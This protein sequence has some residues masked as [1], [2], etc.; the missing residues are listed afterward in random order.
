[1][2]DYDKRAFVMQQIALVP[3]AK[4]S[5]D[6]TMICCC[7]HGEKTPSLCV[8]HRPTDDNPGN[9]YC[10]G[11]GE[12]GTW[13]KLADALGLERFD[14]KPRDRYTYPLPQEIEDNQAEEE[15]ILSELPSHKVWRQLPT[16]FLKEIGCKL[17]QV[18]YLHALSQR[19]IY[20]PVN[21]Q[22]KTEGYIKA[23]MRKEPG[24][25]SYINK[26]GSW[27]KSKGLFPYDYSIARMSDKKAVVLVEG[28]RDALRLLHMGIPALC[29]MGTQNWNDKKSQLLDIAGVETAIIMMDGDDA[30]IKGTKLV[31]NSVKHFVNKVK[32]VKLWSWE[33]SPYL[34][35]KNEE[36]PSQAAKKAGIELWD[37]MNC[38]RQIIK[39]IKELV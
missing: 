18:K 22:G 1:M 38:P 30:G 34:D 25:P 37:P 29:I 19:Y 12:S 14:N 27:V 8:Y 24:K 31:Y 7:F 9:F 2:I 15:L 23:R 36:N 20:M 16:D 35:F 3:G 13:N 21:I 39:Q 10:F 5:A 26:R 32:I 6:R 33:G 17:C 11:C 28:Q 4:Q